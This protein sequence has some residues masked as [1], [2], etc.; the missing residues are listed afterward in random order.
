MHEWRNAGKV[1]LINLMLIIARMDTS[2]SLV[3]S[4]KGIETISI[5]L[6]D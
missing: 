3:N 1:N 4:R 5:P 2:I 6:L